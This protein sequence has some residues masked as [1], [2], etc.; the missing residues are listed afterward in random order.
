MQYGKRDATSRSIQR[1]QA[2]AL[3]ALGEPYASTVRQ[4]VVQ[5]FGQP[6]LEAYRFFYNANFDV[7]DSVEAYAFGNYARSKGVN[8]FNWRAPAAAAG[9]AASSAYAR[10]TFQNGPNAVFPDWDLHSVFPGGFTPRFGSTQDDYSTVVGAR[11]ELT[12]NLSWD[13]SASLG[14]NTIEYSLSETINASLGPLS[15]TSFD[16]GSREQDEMNANVDFVYRWQSAPSKSRSTSP[17]VPSIGARS[18]RSTRA[19]KRPG[20]S[21]RCAISRRRPTDFPAPLLLQAGS[22][23]IDSNAAYVDVDIDVN[24]GAGTSALAGR[25]ED[26]SSFGSTTNGKLSTRFKVFEG[27]HLR[28]A[29]S[30][31][32]RAPTPGQTNLTNTSQ[33]PDPLT[34]VVRTRGTDSA[35]QRSGAV[36]LG[37]VPLEPETSTN[38]SARLRAYSRLTTSRFRSTPIASTSTTASARRR[39]SS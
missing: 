34:G 4:P 5:R 13:A 32:F 39:A 14:H 2:E 28:G 15:P 29:A 24:H 7:N 19:R 20:S 37:A 25:F 23:S 9:F 8:D 11:G 10:S 16:A 17:S 38:F 22:W 36:L 33:F 35:D 30:T 12:P 1:P 27:F 3:I 6:D 18:S 31:G 26:Y 21:G